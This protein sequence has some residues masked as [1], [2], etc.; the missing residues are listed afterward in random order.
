MAIVEFLFFLS[1]DVLTSEMVYQQFFFDD[2]L[3]ELSLIIFPLIPIFLFKKDIPALIYSIVVE[4]VF[5]LFSFGILIMYETT[6][7]L[8][9]WSSITLIGVAEGVLNSSYIPW[10]SIAWSVSI[11]AV[12]IATLVCIF[13]FTKVKKNKGNDDGKVQRTTQVSI[14]GGLAF[15]FILFNSIS[16]AGLGSDFLNYS[17]FEIS[18]QGRSYLKKHGTMSY[19]LTDLLSEIGFR[20]VPNDTTDTTTDNKDYVTDFTGV[21]KDYNVITIMLESG[22]QF[23]INETLTPNIYSLTQD[24]ISMTNNKSKNK[25]NVS[26]FIGLTGI[27]TDQSSVSTGRLKYDKSMVSKLNELGYTTSYFHDNTEAF[28]ERRTEMTNL[29]FQNITFAEDVNPEIIEDAN[30]FNGSYPLDSEFV[31]LTLDRMVPSQDAPFYTFFT[32]F[33]THGPYWRGGKDYGKFISK[34]YYDKLENAERDGLWTNICQDDETEI[35]EQIKYLTCAMMDTDAAVGKL[36]DRLKEL[37]I[38]D[39]TVFCLYGDHENY[40]K[41]NNMD[42]LSFYVYDTTDQYD[43]RL[44]STINLISNPNL[45]KAYASKYNLDEESMI[46]YTDFTTPYVIVPT[47]LDVMGISYSTSDYTGKSI[48]STETKYDNIFYSHELKFYMVDDITAISKDDIVYSSNDDESDLAL[49]K[50]KV[51]ELILTI[52]NMDTILKSSL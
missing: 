42:N 5:S 23:L 38:Y 21:C 29:K 47:L 25:T 34:G 17:K 22:A 18:T 2:V 11:Y 8:F 1:F 41:S 32:T 48:F 20:Y 14:A 46:E 27:G 4:L 10:K 36:I 12:T 26:E 28:Y 13:V 44:Y 24:G 3:L 6:G 9:K 7:E 19:M 16:L 49:F 50:E 45:K 15:F 35:Q 40:Y 39:K 43:P 51:E 31:D 33:V 37:G 30:K 52:Y